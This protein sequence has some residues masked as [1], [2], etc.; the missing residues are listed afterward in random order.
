M[1]LLLSYATK[2]YI[3]IKYDLNLVAYND[4]NPFLITTNNFYNIFILLLDISHK[5]KLNDI[6]V[7]ELWHYYIKCA[8][9]VYFNLRN[10]NSKY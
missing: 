5:N 2:W 4:F 8:I 1:L 7:K 9:R 10:S 6:A 3:N